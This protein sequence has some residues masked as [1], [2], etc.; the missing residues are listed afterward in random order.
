MYT[1]FKQLKVHMC[2]EKERITRQMLKSDKSW[3]I[4]MESV[5]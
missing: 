5:H 4:N 2:E 3:K 1:P